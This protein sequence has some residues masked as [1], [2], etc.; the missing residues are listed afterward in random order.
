V[1]NAERLADA[2]LEIAGG[3]LEAQHERL[4][5]FV[6]DQIE[7]VARRVED[8]VRQRVE[9][10]ETALEGAQLEAE[11]AGSE[12]DVRGAARSIE[13]I[14]GVRITLDRVERDPSA[15]REA[16][17]SQIQAALESGAWSAVVQAIERRV[18][19]TLGLTAAPPSPIEWDAVTTSLLETL[20]RLWANRID[21]VLGQIR[22]EIEPV[23]ASGRPLD[24]PTRLRLLVRMSYGQRTLFDAKTHQRR[25]IVVPRLSYTYNAARWIEN[26]DPKDL[27]QDVL[28]HLQGA[29]EALLG[30]IGR[31]EL[32]R[33]GG[34]R[35]D[36]FDERRQAWI[37][38]ILGE[39]G[40]AEAATGPIGQLP[41]EAK[42]KLAAGIGRRLL[43]EFHRRLILSVGDRL[44]VEYLTQMEALRTSIGL[45]AYGQ[46]DP[47]VQYKSRAF[48]LFQALL[49]NIR[50]GVVSSLFRV[51]AAPARAAA[52]PAVRAEA[53]TAAPEP[54]PQ[55]VEPVGED[56]RKRRRR[57]R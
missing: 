54:R 37:R 39:E 16:V 9:A 19:E 44:W 4:V 52:A 40:F 47:L 51:A 45:E 34:A 1:S 43:A 28:R 46:R 6:E 36:E 12:L 29:Q 17:P 27:T 38:G 13:E 14:T 48:D 56:R 11:E 32:A 23:L 3:S 2:L 33:I 22:S 50:S 24:D 55:P 57:H 31:A 26:A 30:S 5:H 35:I 10:A 41:D 7:R 25:T 20:D 53:P 18:G 42:S 21:A 15:L 49:D 8:Q